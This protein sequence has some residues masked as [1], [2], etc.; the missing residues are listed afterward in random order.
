VLIVPLQ[1]VLAGKRY[2]VVLCRFQ[3]LH[4]SSLVYSSYASHVSK[5]KR[6]TVARHCLQHLCM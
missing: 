1:R 5:R 2:T 3:H 4:I 6:H